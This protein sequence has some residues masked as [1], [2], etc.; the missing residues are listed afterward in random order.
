MNK[1]Y[2]FKEFVAAWAEAN[3]VPVKR[4]G[5]RIRKW[6]YGDNMPTQTLRSYL[7]DER[8]SE[9]LAV[10]PDGIL[11]TLITTADPHTFQ[12]GPPH[13]PRS[14]PN[15]KCSNCG[16]DIDRT[17]A[18]YTINPTPRCKNCASYYRDMGKERPSHLWENQE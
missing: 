15:A 12:V 3:D 1:A 2:T 8:Y 14:K 13:R 17:V 5:N 6:F 9:L 18:G 10:L 4:A 11:D 16:S 7:D